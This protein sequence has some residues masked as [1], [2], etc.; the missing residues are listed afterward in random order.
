MQ[1]NIDPIIIEIIYPKILKKI[2]IF[3]IDLHLIFKKIKQFLFN[4]KNKIGSLKVY[5]A[6]CE[7]YPNCRNYTDEMIQEL[8]DENKI[9][10]IENFND[11]YMKTQKYEFHSNLVSKKQYLYLVKCEKADDNDKLCYF[12]V[13]SQNEETYLE[14]ISKKRFFFK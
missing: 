2:N 13:A 3:I 6:L 10:E 9:F 11:F 1:Y 12:D 7:S 4:V 8:K 5:I 14:L